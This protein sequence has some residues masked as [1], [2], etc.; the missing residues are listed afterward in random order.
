MKV[1][2]PQDLNEIT[3]KQMIKL[4][5]IEKLEIDE[6]EKAKEVIKLLVDKVDDSNINRIK[7]LD[8]LAM[9][10]KLC[11]MTNTETSLIKLVSIEG[12]KYGFNPDIQSISTGEFMDIDMLCKDLDKNLHMIMAILYRKVTTEGEGKYLI[13]EYDAKIDERANLFLNKMPASV[14]QSCLVFFYRLGGGC[15]SDTMVSLQEEEKANQV[16]TLESDGVGIPS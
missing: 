2:I 12:V 9:Y 10:K 13:E 8:L 7:V 11:A 15:L 5:D 4:A 3:L 6:V 14:A 16:Q 1:I